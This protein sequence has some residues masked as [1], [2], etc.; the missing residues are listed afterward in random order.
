MIFKWQ[1]IKKPV[2][3]LG[4]MA[5]ITTQPLAKLCKQFG[6]DIIFTPMISSNA[7]CYNEKEAL[8]IAKF[9]KKDQPVIVQ[10]FGHDAEL[11]INAIKII[12][13][14]LK[15]DGFDINLG[16]PAPKIIK[17]MAGS[18]FLKDQ[19]KAFEFVKKIRENYSG[20]L[21]VKTRLGVKD[22]EVAPLL[23]KFEE[24]GINAITLH[25]RTVLQKYTGK[26]DWN[27]I[28]NIANK[29]KIPIIL[30]GDIDSWEKAHQE[31]NKSNILGIMISRAAMSKPWIFKEIKLKKQ[32]TFSKSQIACLMKKHMKY[33]LSY[34]PD[35]AFIEMR[36][37]LVNYLKGFNNAKELRKTAVQI[38][39]QQDF[40]SLIKNLK[41]NKYD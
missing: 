38:K 17:S 27:T 10:L 14:K 26:A 2:F 24:I 32:L 29:L 21:S 8:H 6:A 36:K 18:A 4:P 33:Y 7:I 28:H 40:N 11:M 39:N 5:S 3:I 19:A 25:G 34:Q 31:I 37:F 22:F 9:D 15:P 30:N 23:K 16:C 12:E 20:Q 35:R 1:N 13:K 41:N